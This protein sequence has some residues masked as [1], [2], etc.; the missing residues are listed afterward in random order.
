MKTIRPPAVAGAFYPADARLL[1]RTVLDYLRTAVSPGAVPKAIIA[2]HA[3]YVY[4]GPVAATAY[5][6]LR[7]ARGRINRV[8]LLGPAHWVAFDGLAVSH[9]DAFRTPLGVVPVDQ[10]AMASILTLPQVC[11]HDEAHAREHSL[12]VHLPFLQTV[13]ETCTIVPLVVGQ[14][15]P[16]AVGEVLEQLWDGPDTVIIVSS[17]LSHDHDYHTAQT[18]DRATSCAIEALQPQEVSPEGACGCYPIRGLLHVARHQGLHA[19]TLDLRNSGDTA[20]PRH[21]VVGYGAYVFV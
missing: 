13:L 18:L 20:G 3:G 16:K 9:A 14:A 21:R 2:P 10:P 4:S 17:D 19:S 12:E 8:V 5:A 15:T 1:Q 7:S 11:V 6:R